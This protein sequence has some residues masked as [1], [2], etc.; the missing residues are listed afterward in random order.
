MLS[1]ATLIHRFTGSNRRYVIRWTN[2][3][4][5]YFRA[6]NMREARKIARE[7]TDRLSEEYILECVIRNED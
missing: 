6:R 3:E 1:D 7:F 2:G 5:A 4:E